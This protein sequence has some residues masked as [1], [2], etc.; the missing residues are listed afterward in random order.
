MHGDP[1][2][3][4]VSLVDGRCRLF[5]FERAGWGSV[6]AD[7]AYLLAP[8]PSCWCFAGMPPDAVGA[9]WRAYEAV[10]AEAGAD[11]GR[12]WERA[13]AAALAG[14]LVNGAAWA[15]PDR[16]DEDWGTT[17]RRPRLLAWSR[18][19]LASPG[20][21]AFPALAAAAARLRDR[22]APPGEDRV[23]YPA[24]PVPGAVTVVPPEYWSP[25]T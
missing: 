7:A 4:N 8:F 2:P 24:L 15:L 14:Y 17:T 20:A 16:H 10:L 12:G 3:D 19:F 9:A 1:C 18:S 23:A 21:G 22:L 11:L 25:S 6:A 5:D 13:V